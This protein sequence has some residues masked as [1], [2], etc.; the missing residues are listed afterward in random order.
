MANQHKSI[1]Q[2]AIERLSSLAEAPPELPPGS[3]AAV[4]QAATE[5]PHLSPS[6][7]DELDAAI[8]SGRLPI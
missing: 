3:A 5:L 4:L 1:Q 7:V 2:L 6:D 8:A